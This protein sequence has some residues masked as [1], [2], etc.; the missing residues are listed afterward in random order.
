MTAKKVVEAKK[1]SGF[2]VPIIREWQKVKGIVLKKI[3]NGVLVDCANASFT[4]IIL[5]K[6][7]KEL[8]RSW[9]DLEPGREI[10]LEIVNPNIRHEDGYYIVSI[11]KLL[12]YDVW[13]AILRKF[14]DDEI[15]SVVPTE[16]NLW[17]LLVDMHGIKWFVPLSQLAPIHYPRVEDGDQEAIFE[18]LL[19][20]IGQELRVRIINIDEEEKRIILSERE[21]LKEER[22]SVLKWL[23]VGKIYEWVVSGISS[24]GLFVTIGGTVE[25][26]VHISEITYGH[27]NNIDNLGKIGD[28]I[29]VKV[30]GLENG[31]ISLSSKKLKDDP[32]T[33]LPKYH[34]VGDI[35]EGEVV[36]YVPYGVFIRVFQ[37]INGLIHLSELSQKTTQNPNEVVKLGQIVK[38]KIIL[39][40]PKNRKIG[41]SMKGVS[42]SAIPTDPAEIVAEK[43]AVKKAAPAKK[44][45]ADVVKK[46]AEEHVEE[47]QP[48]VKKTVK[49]TT[50][51]E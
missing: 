33:E 3:S 48:V 13:K 9:Y 12:Q 46:L 20:L 37:D 2:I 18:K 19:D 44:G 43:P 23:E 24:Y 50:K 36:R 16:A 11:T 31:K 39:L 40:D 6:E 42:E 15:I 22:E 14:E 26:L 47:E 17:G 4:G 25:G 41:L 49:K 32:W 1:P 35:L 38:A 10:E 51:E 21:A 34:K 45:L 8:E 29:T 5:S 28:K 30:I 27:V 7:V